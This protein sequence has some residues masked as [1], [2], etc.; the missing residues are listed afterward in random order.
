MRS[1][2]CHN[3]IILSSL[4]SRA[5]VATVQVSTLEWVPNAFTGRSFAWY[6]CRVYREIERLFL[7]HGPVSLVAHSQGGILALI[8]LG[9]HRYDGAL[10]LLSLFPCMNISKA[11][12]VPY[13]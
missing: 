3:D 5:A 13:H 8:C 6:L 4:I 2:T 9:P 11:P 1:L 12:I 10:V 7:A